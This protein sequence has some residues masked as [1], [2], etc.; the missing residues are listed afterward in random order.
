MLHSKTGP[1]RLRHKYVSDEYGRH[2][3]SVQKRLRKQWTQKKRYK[4]HGIDDEVYGKA[5]WDDAWRP[6]KGSSKAR[7]R[8]EILR[9]ERQLQRALIDTFDF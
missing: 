6:G 2:A 9:E 8:I 3:D 5:D 1:R 4:P 7:Q